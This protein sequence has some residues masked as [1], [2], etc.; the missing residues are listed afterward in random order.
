MD[1]IRRNWPDLLIGVA[2]IAVIA[3]IVMTLL[4]G[5]SFLPLGGGDD[6]TT[7]VTR[8]NDPV[9]DDLPPAIDLAETDSDAA[10]GSEASG[11]DVDR[12]ANEDGASGEE[13]IPV[14]PSFDG[15]DGTAQASDT[16]A[17]NPTDEA[18]DTSND[19]N[20]DANDATVADSGTASNTASNADSTP[21]ASAGAD[22]AP[23]RIS[24]GAYNSQANAERRA[25]QVRDAGY[26]V[27]IGQEDS[28]YLVL[29][30]PY[31]NEGQA[32]TVAGRIEDDGIEARPTIYEFQGDPSTDAA[33]STSATVS[34][35]S[36][37]TDTSDTDVAGAGTYIQVGAYNDVDSSLPQRELLEGLGYTV[38]EQEGGGLIRLW[39]G[40]FSGSELDAVQSRLS[41]QG[42]DHFIP[43]Q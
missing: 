16:S 4:G 40:P 30:G 24:V 15:D 23:Y 42:I 43:A 14:L 31:E 37:S 19:A 2:L 1:W 10:D 9:E 36:S 38:S 8:P 21:S 41:S 13:I 12:A 25:Q 28:L 6:T 35:E 39:I 27:F 29:V 7:P 20:T 34:N 5:G 17:A 18:N 26:P 33:P 3:G 22:L 11:D 32:Q